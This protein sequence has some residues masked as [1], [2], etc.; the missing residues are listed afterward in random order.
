MVAQADLRPGPAGGGLPGHPVVPARPD[1]ALRPRAGPGLRAGHRPLG[2][3]PLPADLGP[4]GRPGVAAGVD[5]DPV[6]AGLQ[7]RRGGQPRGHLR[8]GDRRHRAADRGRAAGRA[9]PRR[10]LDDRREL[11]R[12]RARAL[13]LPAAV[14]PGRGPRRAHRHPRLL[15]HHRVRHRPGAPVT[16]LR[17]GRPGELPR[18][19]PA[20]GQPGPT[21]RDLRAAGPAGRRR[22]LQNRGPRAGHRSAGPRPA[23]PRDPVRAQLPALLALPHAADLLRPPVLVRPHD[24]GP[25]PDAP[26]ERA[27]QLAA[28]DDQ[29]RPLRRLAD[30]QRRLGAL[31]PALLGHSPAHLALRRRAPDLRRL[32]GRP[33]REGGPRPVRAGPAPPVH[34]RDHLR[35][36]LRADRHPGPRRD[37]RLVRL[38]GD[39]VRPVRL[40]VPEQGAVRA[41]LPGPVHL[42]GDRPDP[43]VVLHADGG[44]DAGVRQVPVR[45]R[46][47]CRAHRGRGRP[48][49]VQAPGQHPRAAAAAGAARRGRGALVHGRGRLAVGLAARRAHHAAGSGPQDPADLLEHGRVP[50]AVRAYGSNGRRRR[51]T[52]RR[53]TARFWTAGCCRS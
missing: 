37:R 43:R 14:R 2:V 28:R 29:A 47:L 24:R 5:D 15:R 19:R 33:G 13:D 45:E 44:R 17:R 35:L 32:P 49:D 41:Q 27:D 6:D 51:R 38:R 11:H 40:P 23:V 30:Q 9:G 39:A 10:G 21:R 22:L 36:R 42:R 4:A 34:R 18:L 53:P 20:D 16:R 31:P 7:H 8:G 52:R 50:G 26:R 46:G 12:Q 3:R 25:R 1:R 48:Q